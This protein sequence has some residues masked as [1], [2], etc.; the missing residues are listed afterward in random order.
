MD[1]D[2]LQWSA[3]AYTRYTTWRRGEFVGT[4]ADG[5][6]YY[7]DKRTAGTRRERRW[8]VYNGEDEAS[9]VPPEWHAWL[10]RQRIDPPDPNKESPFRR[11]WQREHIPNLSGTAAAYLPPGD[12]LRGGQRDRATGDYEPWVPS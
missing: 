3:R 11:P 9:R 1:F 5:N 6:K 10:H 2:L 12:A 7:R 4:D 8:V